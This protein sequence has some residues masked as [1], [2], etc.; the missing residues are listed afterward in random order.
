MVE[1]KYDLNRNC[2][3]EM[4]A[5]VMITICSYHNRQV[6]GIL[7][8]LVLE[9]KIPFR[10]LDQMVLLIE[11]ILDRE[12]ICK[13]AFEYRYIEKTEQEDGWLENSILQKHILNEWNTEFH[14]NILIRI[15]GRYHR[16]LQGMVRVGKETVYFRSG[17]E[18]IRMIHQW[19]QSSLKG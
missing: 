1:E 11:E 9:E 3:L 15:Y 7:Q 13:S 6:C 19:L 17:M 10:G 2:K 4:A 16:S 5:T 18:L 14:Q 12:K 8:S